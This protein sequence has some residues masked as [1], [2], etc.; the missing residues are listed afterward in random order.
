M[1]AEAQEELFDYFAPE[2]SYDGNL[3][4][5]PLREE[6]SPAKAPAP[7]KTPQ[8]TKKSLPLWKRATVLVA[9][10]MVAGGLLMIAAGYSQLFTTKQKLAQ[11]QEQLQ[12]QIQN[13]AVLENGTAEDMTLSELYEYAT[14]TLGM[15]EAT[16]SEITQMGSLDNGYTVQQM[17]EEAVRK[18][19]QVRFH[20]FGG[21]D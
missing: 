11:M 20:L 7:K 18:P 1:S 12:E 13:T 4:N 15:R 5:Q 17:Q 6:P 21:K 9:V 19:T 3:A 8:V 16:G 14:G 10:L 2:A